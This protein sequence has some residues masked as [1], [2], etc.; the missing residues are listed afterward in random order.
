M[1]LAFEMP[2]L[3]AKIQRLFLPIEF[4]R[5][6]EFSYI[7]KF[8]EKNR[9]HI[10]KV[11]DISSP[12][13]LSY[14]WKRKKYQ[15]TKTDINS[16]EEKNIRQC[17]NLT[18]QVEDAVNLSFDDNYFDLTYSISVIEHIYNDYMTAINE[19]IRV[20][21]KNGLIYLTFPVSAEHNEIWLDHDIYSNQQKKE[22]RTFFYYKFDKE[23]VEAI[24]D[25]IKDKASV[26]SYDIYWES[27]NGS[28]DLTIKMLKA[29][30]FGKYLSYLKNAIIRKTF[31]HPSFR[32]KVI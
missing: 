26:L 1:Y 22:G 31:R 25:N 4:T 19:M 12:Y 14:Y 30:F 15:I 20:T 3:K 32:L 7:I 6:T 29:N 24:F 18:F 9:S 27:F 28:Y 8:I 17:S 2:G 21:K 11:L 5:Y 16:D 13:M 10:F 23:D